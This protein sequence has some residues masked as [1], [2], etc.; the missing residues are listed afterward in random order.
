MSVVPFVIKP[1]NRIEN[2]GSAPVQGS[3]GLSEIENI[4]GL[5]LF[6]NPTQ[7]WATV[8]IDILAANDVEMEILNLAGQVVMSK[9]YGVHNGTLNFPINTNELSNGMYLVKM[10]V[11]DSIHTE[12]LQV[13]K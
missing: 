11:G 1:N 3:N 2:G 6:P 7:N 13:S 9:N 10:R 4:G 5:T 12:R 8:Q